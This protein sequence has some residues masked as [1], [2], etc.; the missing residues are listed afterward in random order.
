MKFNKNSNGYIITYTTILIVVVAALLSFASISLKSKQD[1]NVEIEKK[2]DILRTIGQGAGAKEAAD[3][4]KYVEEEY[5]K[6]ITDTYAVNTKGD[7]IDGANAFNILINLKAEYDKP[8]AERELPIFVSKNGAEVHY[9]IP[10]YGS[11]LWGP[12]W[13]YIALN[14]NWDTVFGVVFDHKGETPGLGAEITTA[15]FTDQFKNKQIYRDGELTGILVLKGSGSSEGNPSAVDA[16]SGGTITSRSVESMIKDCLGNYTAYFA[17]ERAA[18]S[19]ATAVEAIPA[20]STRLNLETVNT[21][22]HE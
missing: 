9:I 11:G 14:G 18:L 1:F 6:Y 13:G 4:T 3:K 19:A 17:K 12:V 20:D 15:Q 8:E 10:V 2:T 21:E 5:S 7:K 22:D 16:I